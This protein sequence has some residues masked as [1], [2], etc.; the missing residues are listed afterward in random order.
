MI[1]P[2]GQMP[3][4]PGQPPPMARRPPPPMQGQ[5]APRPGDDAWTAASTK[6]WHGGPTTSPSRYA[7]SSRWR[8]AGVWPTASGYATPTQSAAEP[9]ES[10]AIII[11][12]Y[13]ACGIF[14]FRCLVMLVASGFVQEKTLSRLLV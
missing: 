7:S 14:H 4:Y 5:F 3:G 13:L 11:G 8:C 1:Q 2:P 9:A 10:A 12:V 6:A